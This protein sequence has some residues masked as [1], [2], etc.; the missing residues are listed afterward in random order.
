MDVFVFKNWIATVITAIFLQ[1]QYRDCCYFRFFT[2]HQHAANI[3]KLTY[4]NIRKD[5]QL[6]LVTGQRTDRQFFFFVVR[7]EFA[8]RTSD[9]TRNVILK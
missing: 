8:S 2:M 9:Q 5:V 6:F 3:W 1:I 7:V 4:G